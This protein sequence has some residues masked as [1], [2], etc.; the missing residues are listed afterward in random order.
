MAALWLGCA[1]TAPAMGCGGAAE[2]ARAS[3]APSA[4][5]EGERPII[6]SCGQCRLV[7][8]LAPDDPERIAGLELEMA[9]EELKRAGGDWTVSAVELK[10]PTGAVQAVKL[11][12]AR[13]ADGAALASSKGLAGAKAA[14]VTFETTVDGKL[15]REQ[16]E[17]PIEARRAGH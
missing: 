3:E 2:Q 5:S 6:P 10:S 9:A 8:H 11:D 15:R 7:L 4:A 1:M 16:V 12:A 14:W 17:V 13:K